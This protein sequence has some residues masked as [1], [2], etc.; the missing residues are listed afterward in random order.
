MTTRSIHTEFILVKEFPH[1][2]EIDPRRANGVA[3]RETG[4]VFVFPENIISEDHMP[5]VN[6]CQCCSNCKRATETG[7]GEIICS[8][9]YDNLM[10][11]I[12]NELTRV[13]VHELIH[14]CARDSEVKVITAT[15]RIAPYYDPCKRFVLKE[16]QPKEK[17]LKC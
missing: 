7:S 6:F 10:V 13:N 9:N 4:E 14:L 5:L 1:K 8:I 12:I 16:E 17:Q 15:K 11:A 3:V 2:Y